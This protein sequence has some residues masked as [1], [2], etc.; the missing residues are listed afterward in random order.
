M[1]TYEFDLAFSLMS[2]SKH[3][4]LINP[5]V[6]LSILGITIGVMVLILTLAI[7]DG[8][9]KKMET[10]IF[11]FYPQLTVKNTQGL[12]TENDEVEE[13]E[14][15]SLFGEQDNERLRCKQICS[16]DLILS[17]NSSLQQEAILKTAHPFALENLNQIKLKLQTV[18]GIS[19]ALPVIFEDAMFRVDKTDND[20]R[21]RVLGITH[22]N[23]KHYVP[24]VERIVKS[25]LLKKLNN[26]PKPTILLAAELYKKL[27]GENAPD[28]LITPRKLWLQRTD[29]EN[30]IDQN[31]QGLEVQ[32]IGVFRLGIH[33]VA[34]NMII[35]SLNTAQKLLGMNGYASMLGITLEK[36]FAA[37][38]TAKIVEKQLDGEKVI[39]F[40][41]LQ[42]ANDLFNSLSLY[43]K[44][45]IV[46]LAMSILITA[47][48]IYN[49]LA[50]LILERKRQVGILIAMGVKKS[51]IYKIFIIIS[52]IQGIL[53]SLLGIVLGTLL[54][55]WFNDYLNQT[56]ANFL[57]V[58]NAE[59]SV[60][61]GIMMGILGFVCLVCAVTSLIP[62][63]QATRIDTVES[64]Q[65]E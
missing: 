49:N 4:Q 33:K 34:D 47:F 62:A 11:S 27:Y 15:V 26:A 16:G 10:I 51:G 63:Y 18:P 21:L 50:I 25:D 19:T 1:T 36:P 29:T 59:I 12:I 32:V 5:N 22:Q 58:Q 31:I 54:G 45:I 64:L 17:D 9:V 41:W 23:N 46:I 6:I 57:P 28:T 35:T 56:L 53:G 30:A 43:R 39:V 42:V 65:T 14:F 20:H 13:F 2:S 7:Y 61:F 3:R 60:G 52:Q 37:E 24:Q 44:M 48:N 8:Y 55:Y 38:Q 40:Q